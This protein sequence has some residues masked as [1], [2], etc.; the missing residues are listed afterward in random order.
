MDQLMNRRGNRN[1]R[2]TDE[3]QS[4]NP[5]GEDDD[6]S[7]DEQSG[8]RPRDTLSPKGFTEWLVAIEEVAED[9]EILEAIIPL[10]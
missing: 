7:S 8:R 9:S 4:E 6:S 1:V 10:L 2:G 5:F 3:E